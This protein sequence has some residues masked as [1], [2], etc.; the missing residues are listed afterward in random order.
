MRTFF[1]LLTLLLQIPPVQSPS[2]ESPAAD[3]SISLNVNLVN[4]VFTVFDRKGHL[5]TSLPKNKFRIYEDNKAQ[6]ITSFSSET[7]LPLSI[8]LLIDTSGSVGDKLVF[9]QQAAVEFLKSTLRPGKDKALLM[10]FDTRAHLLQDYTDDTRALG[11]AAE[12]IRSGGSTAMYDALYLATSE[13]LAKKPGRH[14]LILISDGVDTFSNRSID[15]A[16]QNAQQNETAIYCISTNSILKNSSGDA[17]KGTKALRRLAEETG[18]RM[19]QPLTTYELSSNFKKIDE[20]LRSQYA[21]TY[22]PNNA[23]QNGV[24]HSIRIETA[25]RQLRVQAR[26][27]YFDSQNN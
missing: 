2:V 4:V 13:K 21:L 27:G 24:F 16:L 25:D 1:T 7:D 8:A 19:F 11:R 15:E 18:G 9:E 5:V 23:S 26:N 14:V 22:H 3:H 10:S 17:A 6:S 12:Q 20:E